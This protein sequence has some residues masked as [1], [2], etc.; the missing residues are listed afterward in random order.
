MFWQV[1]PFGN[2]FWL[3][4]CRWEPVLTAFS[5]WEQL[6]LTGFFWV[7]TSSDSFQPVWTGSDWSNHLQELLTRHK[8]L[9]ADF[10]EANYDSVFDH[11]QRLLNS[12]NYVTRRQALKVNVHMLLFSWHPSRQEAGWPWLPSSFCSSF[13]PHVSLTTVSINSLQ[14]LLCFGVLH[15]PPTLSR[16]LLTQSGLPRLLFLHFLGICSL[17]QFFISRSFNMAGPFKLTPQM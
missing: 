10:L 12:E 3:V 15:S 7:G 9:C 1:S 6:A 4:L 13:F 17:C 8:I 16:S 14:L 2:Q 11:Y 5:L